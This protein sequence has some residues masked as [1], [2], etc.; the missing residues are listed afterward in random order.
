MAD[1]LGGAGRA[2]NGGA[3][4]PGPVPVGEGSGPQI[5]TPTDI[6]RRR[7]E[8]EEAARQQQAQV[9][10]SAQQARPSAGGQSSPTGRPAAAGVASQS[11]PLPPAAASSSRRQSAHAAAAAGRSPPSQQYSASPDTPG[12]AAAGALPVSDAADPSAAG[13][14]RANRQSQ[15]QP[16]P[17][18]P[19]T[20]A[21]PTSQPPRQS[22]ASSTAGPSARPA[23]ASSSPGNAS[24][25]PHAFERWETMSSHWEGLTSYWI[26]RLEQNTQELRRDPLLQQL[27]RQVTDLSQAGANLFHAV[28]ELQRLRASSERKFSRWFYE[29]RKDLE[30]HQEIE[31]QL[32]AQLQAERLARA[33]EITRM[34][35][36]LN[37]HDSIKLKYTKLLNDKERELEISRGEARRAWEE[38]G[39]AAA[40]ERDRTTA[41]KDG[42]AISVGG[43]QVVPTTHHVH[44]EHSIGGPS[45]AEMAARDTGSYPPPPLHG[46]SDTNMD[47]GQQPSPSNTDPFAESNIGQSMMQHPPTTNGVHH[48]S[49]TQPTSLPSTFYQHPSTLLHQEQQQAHPHHPSH[50]HRGHHPQHHPVHQAPVTSAPTLS[51]QASDGLSWHPSEDATSENDDDPYEYDEQGVLRRDEFGQPIVHRRGHFASDDDDQVDIAEEIERER[52]MRAQQHYG[53]HLAASGVNYPTV[54]VSTTSKILPSL[55]V[56]SPSAGVSAASIGAAFAADSPSYTTAPPADYEGAGYDWQPAAAGP[57]PA[58]SGRPLSDVVEVD[59]DQ[60][61][62]VS[63]LSHATHRATAS[64]ASAGSAAATNPST[65]GHHFGATH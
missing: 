32:Q 11:P 42:Q 16:R 27:S 10:A 1:L 17:V 19:R 45:A 43:I 25:F 63:E 29:T 58:T 52:V 31:A 60:R 26:R 57:Y 54:P 9:A 4:A 23:G 56:S 39:R 37:E 40:E 36:L 7:R 65:S 48:P 33:S 41:L 20:D 3:R 18:N 47:D 15:G 61:S 22:A 28:I 44:R 35:N 6:M 8:R 55:A 46:I 53:G 38:L 13:K 49:S 62:R 59:E 2:S 24:T 12:E 30:R 21:G 5:R 50:H 34:E 51:S 14:Q 64:Q